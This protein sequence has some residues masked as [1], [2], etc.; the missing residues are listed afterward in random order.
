MHVYAHMARIAPC[1]IQGFSQVLDGIESCVRG[2]HVY[3]TT[4]NP[5]LGEELD[6]QHEHGKIAHTSHIL[7]V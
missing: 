1:K 7:Q 6:C 5:A 4:W 3:K 2:Y